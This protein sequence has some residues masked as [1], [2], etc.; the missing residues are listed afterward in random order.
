MDEILFALKEI[1][2]ILKI[3]SCLDEG[4]DYQAISITAFKYYEEIQII[5]CKLNEVI[6]SE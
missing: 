1:E 4:I 2:A 6:H 5:I 3:F